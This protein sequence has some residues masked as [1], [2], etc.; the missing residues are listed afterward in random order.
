[1]PEPSILNAIGDVIQSRKS[2]PTSEPS[3]V[4]SLLRGGVEKIGAKI[5]EE[6]AELVEAASEPGEAGSRHVIHEAADLMFHV[7]VLLGHAD[8]P[9][10]DVETELQRRFGTSGIAEKQSRGRPSPPG[11]E[12]I[13]SPAI[14]PHP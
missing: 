6:A 12:T 9:W 3:Y 2:A 10:Q 1:M 7:L 8:I 5:I 11:T 4:A 13:E 14:G